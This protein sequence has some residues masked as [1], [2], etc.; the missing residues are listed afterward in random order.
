MLR[1]T[2]QG[3]SD[4]TT[5]G[6]WGT[7]TFART[8]ISGRVPVVHHPVDI[9]ITCPQC[10]RCRLRAIPHPLQRGTVQL[11]TRSNRSVGLPTPVTKM[12]R[13]SYCPARRIAFS[14]LAGLQHSPIGEGTSSIR[15]RTVGGNIM[16]IRSDGASELGVARSGIEGSVSDD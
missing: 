13:P 1:L 8:I 7:R 6:I 9:L 15:S 12:Q 16:R 5:A 2:Y 3:E 14:N 4:E 10:P 11:G